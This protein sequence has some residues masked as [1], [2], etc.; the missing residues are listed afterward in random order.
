[1][2]LW[3]YAEPG[4]VDANDEMGLVVVRPPNVRTIYL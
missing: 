3:R 1:M 4:P 2:A